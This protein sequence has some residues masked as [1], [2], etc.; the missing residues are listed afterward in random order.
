LKFLP[1]HQEHEPWGTKDKIPVPHRTNSGFA[2]AVG[3]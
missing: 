3:F 1:T 2:E